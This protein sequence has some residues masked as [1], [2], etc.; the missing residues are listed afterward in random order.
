M[1]RFDFVTRRMCSV[2][3]AVLLVLAMSATAFGADTITVDVTGTYGQTEARSMLKLV[4][5]FRTG[6]YID[7]GQSEVWAYAPNGSVDTASYK[8]LGELKYDYELEKAA[9]QRAMETAL[10]FSH[11]RPYRDPD[12]DTDSWLTVFPDGYSSQTE[13]IAYGYVN[14]NINAQQAF[15]SW[16]E[17]NDPYDRQGHRRGMLS[18]NANRI[19]IGHV[20]M[21][22]SGNLTEGDRPYPLTTEIHYWVMEIGYRSDSFGLTQTPAKD[23]EATLAIDVLKDNIKYTGV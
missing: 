7:G 2:V 6:R 11:E 8:N 13:N 14:N 9:M 16:C 5:D 12:I 1:K 19:G 17:T 21:T 23:D 15:N 10:Q 4:N 20:V 18:R 22:F 3:L